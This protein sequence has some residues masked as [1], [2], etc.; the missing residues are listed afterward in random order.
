[1]PSPALGSVHA[2][3]HAGPY[4]RW[5]QRTAL[6]DEGRATGQLV[7]GYVIEGQYR[8]ADGFLLMLSLDC[9]FDESYTFLLLGTDLTQRARATFVDCGA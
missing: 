4:D 9:P 8:C 1:M 2:R 7:P 3:T 6:L 5:A